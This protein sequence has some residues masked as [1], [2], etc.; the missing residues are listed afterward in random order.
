MNPEKSCLDDQ[1][2]HWDGKLSTIKDMF[3][4]GPSEA[5]R[6]AIETFKR[7]GSRRILELGGGQ[8][9]DTVFFALNGLEVVSLDYSES[10][11]RVIG[12]KAGELGLSGCV[13]ALCHDVRRPLPF[14]VGSFE[15]CFAHM[16]FCM[17]LTGAEQEALATEVL[18]V[19]K[20]GG[21]HIYT[22]RNTDD[23]H[24]REGIH[25]G[26]EMY[27]M[28]GFIVHF[29]DM[30]KV[31]RLAEGYEVLSVDRLEESRLPR[32]LFMVTMRKPG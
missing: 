20:P 15:G 31:E 23:P 2:A 12:E 26:E 6:R 4:T 14:P 5:A 27:E 8:G 25:R 18:R 1:C 24:Y 30:E 3:G 28:N 17:A 21:I 13:T 22:V 9:R 19:L 32:R 16:L 7:S 10:G 29:F 11:V